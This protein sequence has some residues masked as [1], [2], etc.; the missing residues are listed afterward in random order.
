MLRNVLSSSEAEGTEFYSPVLAG[1]LT[2]LREAS[3]ADTIRDVLAV[4]AQLEPDDYTRYLSRYCGEGLERYGDRWS[5]ADI[6]TVMLAATK[7]VAPRTYLEIGVRRG[8]SMAMLAAHAHDASLYGFDLWIENYAGMPNPGG[9]FVRSELKRVG[10]RGHVELISGDSHVTVPRFLAD[11]PDLTLDVVTVDGDH[12]H[13]GALADLRTVIPRISLGGVLVFD[14][15]V[16]PMHPYLYDVWRHAV[17][18]DGGLAAAEYTELGYGVAFAVRVRPPREARPPARK[19]ISRARGHLRDLGRLL[20][21]M[22]G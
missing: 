12:S 3:S 9:D 1:P 22:R 8:R 18:E 15:I 20:S 13:D 14:D 21:R 17:D 5:Y 10:H 6:C 19:A 16:H 11:H 2:L 4:L 7:L